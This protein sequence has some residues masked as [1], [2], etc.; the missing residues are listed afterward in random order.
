MEDQ[1]T[2]ATNTGANRLKVSTGLPCQGVYEN[3]FFVLDTPIVY[4]NPVTSTLSVA[5]G[6]PVTELDI[7]VYAANGEL[8]L[9]APKQVNT[10]ELLLDMSLLSN[11]LYYLV[12]ES[13]ERRYASKI[14]KR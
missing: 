12:I 14:V 11:G 7:K 4:P 13:G 9:S 10:G 5:L 2:L 8:V 6:W 1:I 3:E